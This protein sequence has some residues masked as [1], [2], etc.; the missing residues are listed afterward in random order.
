MLNSEDEKY[1]LS[2]ESKLSRVS[3]PYLRRKVDVLLS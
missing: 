1:S 2:I 3:D